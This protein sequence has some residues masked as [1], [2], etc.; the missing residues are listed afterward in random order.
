MD[1]SIWYIYEY[2]NHA[3]KGRG[4]GSAEETAVYSLNS[5]RVEEVWNSILQLPHIPAPVIHNHGMQIG[6]ML[7]QQAIQRVG[8]TPN[9]ILREP[10]EDA[11]AAQA[12]VVEVI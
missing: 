7:T 12:I 2:T 6:G 1:L 5:D 10:H 4:S 9:G 8:R 11:L 3:R